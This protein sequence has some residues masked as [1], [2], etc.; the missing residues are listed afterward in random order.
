LP[1]EPR[2]DIAISAFTRAFILGDE[3]AA[4]QL[5][6]ILVKAHR[7]WATDL[8]DFRRATGDTK[9]FAGALLI[10]RHS[11]FHPRVWLAFAPQWWCDAPPPGQSYPNLPDAALSP[12][13]RTQAAEE[14]GRVQEAGPAQSFLAPIVMS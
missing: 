6:P 9:R 5:V 3:P 1:E 2:T 12:D 7:S 10:A 14:I 13:D 11:E 4:D 8:D